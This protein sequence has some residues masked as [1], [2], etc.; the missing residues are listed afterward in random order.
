MP[1]SITMVEARAQEVM[2]KKINSF[3]K[4]YHGKDYQSKDELNMFASGASKNL[5]EINLR[6]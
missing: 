4:L 1:Q 2:R 5:K 6:L 3:D